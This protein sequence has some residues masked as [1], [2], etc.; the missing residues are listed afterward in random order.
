[1]AVPCQYISTLTMSVDR[2]P[3]PLF[4]LAHSLLDRKGFLEHLLVCCEDY[5]SYLVD[6]IDQI[7]SVLESD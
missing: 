3:V 7:L 2:H 5:L 6:K 4:R 1:M